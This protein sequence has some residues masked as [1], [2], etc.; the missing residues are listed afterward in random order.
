MVRFAAYYSAV[1]CS[2]V[3]MSMY[4]QTNI[5]LFNQLQ[6]DGYRTGQLRMIADAY[7]LSA[8]LFTTRFETSGKCFMS[9][10][11]GTASILSA[12]A[13]PA[14]LVAAGLVHNVYRNGDFGDYR[15]K[16]TES[17]RRRIRNTIGETAE[18]YVYGFATRNWNAA[19][20]R[21]THEQLPAMQE[22][23]RQVVLLYLADQLEK[24]Q[25]L[26]ILYRRDYQ[27]HCRY[28]QEFGPLLVDMAGQ[29][30]YAGL[31]RQLQNAIQITLGS[32]VPEEL[33]SDDAR[34]FSYLCI[35]QSCRSKR[36]IPALLVVP[37]GIR[38]MFR[39]K[40]QNQAGGAVAGG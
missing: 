21:E 11:V 37:R 17:K 14:E 8:Q 34:R 1:D 33:R 10:V 9:H 40:Q 31:A 18:Q 20:L 27:Q 24:H 2:R 29:L 30:G 7:S 6:R 4:A 5:Q 28:Y 32:M 26:E 13:A 22:L 36:M 15:K 38:R 3:R 39:K 25:D 12:N 35:P 16:I 19:G 23:E